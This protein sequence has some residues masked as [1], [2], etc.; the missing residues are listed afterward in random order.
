M[1]DDRNNPLAD[2]LADLDIEVS[3]ES[4]DGDDTPS[5]SPEPTPSPQSPTPARDSDLSDEELFRQALD[6]IDDGEIPDGTDP[7]PAP[8]ASQAASS[9]SSQTRQNK[10]TEKSVKSDRE[11]FEEAVD[12]IDPA[13]LYD[14]K[15]RGQSGT[16]RQLPDE[17]PDD[18]VAASQSSPSTAGETQEMDEARARQQAQQLQDEA[19][20]QKMVG[21]VDPLEGRDKY[22][23]SRRSAQSRPSKAV[24][25]EGLSTPSLPQSGEGLNYIPPLADSQKSLLRRHRQF[26]PDH[27]V[28]QLHLRGKTRRNALEQLREFIPEHHGTKARFVRIIPGRGL[29]SNTDPVLKPT[30]LQ[31]LEGPGIEYIRGYAPERLQGG[32]YGSLI[33]ELA[34]DPD[35]P[36]NW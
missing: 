17:T 10:A 25:K 7:G 5:G 27:H 11:L 13:K 36:A 4:P 14:A 20:F 3:D 16:D 26:E 28:P 33:V 18:P 34:T 32:D 8:P 19:L 23:R 6:D 15:F 21:D 30:V 12:D 29:Q 31:W 2:Q 22:H 24:S 9:A 35:E 1:S